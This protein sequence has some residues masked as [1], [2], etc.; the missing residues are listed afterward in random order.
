MTTETEPDVADQSERSDIAH[1]RC[2]ICQPEG[3]PEPKAVCGTVFVTE[4][5]APPG[6]QRC[7]VCLDME[8]MHFIRHYLRGDIPYEDV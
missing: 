7:A 5:D 8:A 4:R 3:V 1:L 6:M 2:L